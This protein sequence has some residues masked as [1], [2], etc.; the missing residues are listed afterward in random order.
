MTEGILT[1]TEIIMKHAQEVRPRA[2]MEL[3]LV[4]RLIA[5]AAAAGY[6]LTVEEY[7]QDGE[8]GYDVKSA[9]FNLDECYVNVIGTDG[10]FL[11]WV[12]LVLGNDG[13]D[14]ISDYLT[15]LDTF[16]SGCNELSD[17]LANGLE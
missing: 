15:S 3:K 13:Y 12:R 8:K 2:R 4:N 5:D 14:A 17:R 9:I 6:K 11:G 10:K 7:E 16:M 1:D